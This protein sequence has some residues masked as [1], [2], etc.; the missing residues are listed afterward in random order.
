[1]KIFRTL[2]LSCLC[3]AAFACSAQNEALLPKTN[4]SIGVAGFSQ[5]FGTPDLLAGYMS[6]NAAKVEPKVFIQLD[7]DFARMLAKASEREF[8][9]YQEA[10]RCT[11]ATPKQAN[12]PA[13]SYWMEI[14]KCMNVDLLVV[15]Q[16]HLWQE[17]IGSDF[18]AER[19]AAVITDIFLLD[20][21]NKELIARSRYDEMQRPLLDNILE[22]D[23]FIE[24]GGKW[25][26]AKQ[27]GQ[28]GMY[29]AVKEFGL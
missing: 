19:P 15:P 3:L 2:I 16:V 10:A 18:G 9:G 4:I 22:L 23:K 28:E 17:R 27:L 21:R 25:V 11:T 29:K 24:R 26:T 5:P 13:F 14:G 8:I 20:I 6:E 7:E 1:M 12:S